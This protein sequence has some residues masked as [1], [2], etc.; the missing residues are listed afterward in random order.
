MV[1][2]SGGDQFHGDLF[3]FLRN[4]DLD[5]RGFFDPTRATFQQ[6]QFGGTFG[7]PIK[8]DKIFFFSDYQGQRTI[9]GIETG[10]VSVPSLANRSGD[11]S[12]SADTLTGKVNGSFLAQT[13][14]DRLGYGVR[15]SE[16]FYTP[17]CNSTAQCVFPDAKIPQAAFA[18][19]STKM[20]QFIAT[21]NLGANEFSP[22][23]ISSGSR[24][25]RARREST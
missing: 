13:L 11:F 4:T 21:P 6:N 12:D 23:R 15:V 18:V 3:E 9:R 1:T 5:A 20:L 17:G 14:S 7:G 24:M 8:K 2:K 22:L 16:P 25:I 10:I 19:P